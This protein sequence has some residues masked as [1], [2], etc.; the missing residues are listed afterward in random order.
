MAAI[1]DIRVTNELNAKRWIIHTCVST[2]VAQPCRTG[3]PQ[4]VVDLFDPTKNLLCFAPFLHQ[5]MS[6]S[7][8]A[9]FSID[10]FR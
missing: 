9:Q 8:L 1:R 6:T 3:V 2:L 4:V 7:T 5:S 10:T